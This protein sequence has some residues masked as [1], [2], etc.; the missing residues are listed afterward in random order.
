[1]R[2]CSKWLAG[3]ALTALP[4]I[5]AAG[6]CTYTERATGL[7][8][9]EGTIGPEYWALL[10]QEYEIC[11]TGKAQSPIDITKA[12]PSR[13]AH[14]RFVYRSMLLRIRNTGRTFQIAGDTGGFME[15]G[16]SRYDLVQ[17]HFHRPSGHALHGRAYDMELHLV[18][19]GKDGE[20]V[21]VGVF[22]KGDEQDNTSI[23]KIW[24]HLPADE[25]EQHLVEQIMV[26]AEDLLPSNRAFYYYQGSLTTPPCTEGVSWYVMKHPIRVSEEQVARFSSFYRVNARPVQE[27]NGRVIQSSLE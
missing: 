19:R 24:E 13:L 10:S 20:R 2:T 3:C 4:L 18:H 6:S 15:I 27:R 12:V 7:W 26:N 25:G 5:L 17:F 16:T 8:G 21:V 9:Y 1:M 14:P 23:Q 11:R 22:M